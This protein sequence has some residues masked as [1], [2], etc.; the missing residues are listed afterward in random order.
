MAVTGPLIAFTK[1]QIRKLEK[2][3]PLLPSESAITTAALRNPTSPG[4]HTPQIDIFGARVPV[5]GLLAKAKSDPRLA[6]ASLE[7]L[8]ARTFWSSKTL[9]LEA[10]L[11]GGGRVAA[12]QV[13]ENGFKPGATLISGGMQIMRAPVAGSPLLI[14]WHMPDYA[15]RL[16]EGLER[17]GFPWR[18]MEGG[19][20]EWIVS[21]NV[22]A[23]GEVTVQYVTAQ[24]YKV[25]DGDGKVLPEWAWRLHCAYARYLLDQAVKEVH[26]QAAK[27]SGSSSSL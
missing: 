21:R 15:I 7:E 13:G 14:Q 19:R 8:W 3:Y 25:G 26:A 24:D 5:S 17:W 6:E 22:T 23:D 12:G 2:A 27:D 9:K 16:F 4:T 18:L 1:W 10:R 20:Q 11:F